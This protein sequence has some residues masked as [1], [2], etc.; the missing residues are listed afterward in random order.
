MTQSL[1]L[2]LATWGAR[3]VVRPSLARAGTPEAAKVSFDRASALFFKEPPFLCH[4]PTVVNSQT[5]HWIRVGKP[6]PRKI[7]L[8]LH[9]GAYLSGSGATHRGMLGRIAKLSGVEICAP[10]YRLL[11]EAPFPAAFDDAQ[12]AWAHLI[13]LG[14]DP[15]DIILGGDSAG[16]GLMLALLADL[17][18]RNEAPAAAF[19][20]S[21]WTDLTL[22][23]DTLHCT[24]EAILPV[25]RIEEAVDQFLCGAARDAPRASPLFADFIAPPP[26]LIQVGSGEALAA[27]ARRMAV[28]LGD[29]AI[30]REKDTGL[31]VFQILDGWLPEARV[32]LQEVADFVQTSF[33][34]AKR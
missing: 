13:S 16:G 2:R 8:Y 10:D 29:A 21:P 4:S 17:T 12:A 24:T 19:T 28:K 34:S 15:T 32:A 31:H 22:S 3:R 26:V 1:R 33:E 30:L 18:Q 14:Y 9:G 23:G 27:D 6:A 25:A 7:I 11:Q 5:F 20:F